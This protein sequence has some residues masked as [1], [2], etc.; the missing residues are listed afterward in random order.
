MII[1]SNYILTCTE[2]CSLKFVYCQEEVNLKD[3]GLNSELEFGLFVF[4]QTFILF[5]CFFI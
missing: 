3:D 4:Y 1:T 5:V 2:H